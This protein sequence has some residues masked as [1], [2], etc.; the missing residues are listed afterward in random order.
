MYLVDVQVGGC[1]G[2]W[3]LKV[4]VGWWLV[5]HVDG[6][7]GVAASGAAAAEFC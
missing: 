4:T 2:W 5:Q 1:G 6:A 7:G 3:L